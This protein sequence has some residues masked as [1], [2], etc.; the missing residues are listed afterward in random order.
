MYML[1]FEA[2]RSQ[3]AR[4]LS[5]ETQLRR[6]LQAQHH[7][8]LGHPQRRLLPVKLQNRVPV[9]TGLVKET[10]SARLAPALAGLRHLPDRVAGIPP[11]STPA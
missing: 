8:L 6:V 4:L 3:T 11:Q 7:R 2:E 5:V 10:T 1:G 9:N